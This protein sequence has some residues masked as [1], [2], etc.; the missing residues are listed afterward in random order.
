MQPCLR[1]GDVPRDLVRIPA[2]G[3]AVLQGVDFTALYGE[4]RPLASAA[5]TRPAT[6]T[7]SACAKFEPAQRA[8]ELDNIDRTPIASNV[9]LTS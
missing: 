6:S 2:V 9:A 1:T 5:C 7:R 3:G 4:P 8:F